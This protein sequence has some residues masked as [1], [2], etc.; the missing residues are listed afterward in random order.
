MNVGDRIKYFRKE[1]KLS[2]DELANKSGISRNALS[3]YELNK[4]QP[5]ITV[6]KKIADVLKIEID[7]LII[8]TNSAIGH[9][10]KTNLDADFKTLKEYREKKKLS[11]EQLS[12]LLDIDLDLIKRLESGEQK[13]PSALVA[14]QLNRFFKPNPPFAYEKEY[15]DYKEKKE[16][17][18]KI[19]SFSYKLNENETNEINKIITSNFMKFVTGLGMD[20]FNDLTNNEVL[21][22]INSE[23][24]YKTLEYLYFKEKSNRLSPFIEKI[25]SSLKEIPKIEK[26][27]W[28][29]AGKE[30]LMPIASHDK[31]GNFTE[32]DYKHDDDLMNDED[33]WK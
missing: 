26:Q 22:I 8:K 9:D 32:E 14:C 13:R 5:N 33:I 3:N 25:E 29:E 12:T 15:I 11:Q 10:Y 4:R 31:E 20:F 28:E 16:S 1:E 23:E 2:Q 24:L 19:K 7:D 18:N 30:Y 17:S 27:I 6:L 21:N